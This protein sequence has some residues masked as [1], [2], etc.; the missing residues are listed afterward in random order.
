MPRQN[1]AI[2]DTNMEIRYCRYDGC[3]KELVKKEHEP[4]HA[5]LKRI[6]CDTKC[7]VAGARKAKHWR[8]GVRPTG[9][10]RVD[11]Y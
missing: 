7:A 3:K 11:N 6:Y 4:M 2:Q 10:R 8:D 5:F 1:T 9:G